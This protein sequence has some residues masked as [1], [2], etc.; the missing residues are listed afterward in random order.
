MMSTWKWESG[1]QG[2]RNSLPPTLPLDKS[3]SSLFSELSLK[4]DDY[5]AEPVSSVSDEKNEPVDRSEHFSSLFP[6]TEEKEL[7]GK[8]RNKPKATCKGGCNKEYYEDTLKK[9]GGMCFRCL[10]KTSKESGI[11]M[12]SPVK[13]KKVLCYGT[14]NKEYTPSTLK[15]H[16]G[17]CARCHTK[18]LQSSQENSPK[19]RRIQPKVRCSGICNKEY[20]SKTLQKYGGMCFRCFQKTLSV[21]K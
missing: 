14:C 20:T 17:M 21:P 6:S 7:S 9:Y 11:E 15:K 1:S 3:S 16:G 19:K 5:P 10:Q 8:G 13:S 4:R 18:S 12:S 2:I